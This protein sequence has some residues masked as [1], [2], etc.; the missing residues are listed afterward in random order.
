MK[1]FAEGVQACSKRLL[2]EEMKSPKKIFVGFER[3]FLVVLPK[4][5]RAFLLKYNGGRPKPDGF[6]VKDHRENILPMH[7]FFGIR[8]RYKSSCLDWSYQE[9]RGRI[10]SELLPIA[11]SHMDDLVCLDLSEERYGQ[12]LFWDLEEEKDFPT[13]DNVYWV[14]DSFSEFLEVLCE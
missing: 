3:E 1:T 5:Y 6:P 12:V 13:W 7:F 9:S 2:R 4:D 8:R 10:P 14:A 11:S